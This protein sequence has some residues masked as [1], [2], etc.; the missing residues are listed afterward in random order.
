[1]GFRKVLQSVISFSTLSEIDVFKVT[2]NEKSLHILPVYLNCSQWETDF[3]SLYEAL[4]LCNHLDQFIVLGDL[5]A[6]TGSEQSILPFHSI[7]HS[8]DSIINTNGKKILSLCN[9]FQFEILNGAQRGDFS[10]N[11][12]FSNHLGQSV[13]D[14]VLAGLNATQY[15]AK[16]D[17]LN[18]LESDH[19]PLSVT[20]KLNDISSTH[21][22]RLAPKMRWLPSR[23][24][25]YQGNLNNILRYQN[26]VTLNSLNNIII[27]ASVKPTFSVIHKKSAW[28]D[29][30]C[31]KARKNCFRKLQI[32]RKFPSVFT[33]NE[34][35]SYRLVYKEICSDKTRLFRDNNVTR[36]KGIRSS[37]DFWKVARIINN[38]NA[39]RPIRANL[40]DLETHFRSTSPNAFG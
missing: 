16:L 2:D 3:N 36:L 25:Q 33:K 7:R 10:G 31:W 39:L 14:Y 9:D 6:R 22:S 30:E 38:N 12:T 37:K 35:N 34:Y 4:A 28:F 40:N 11:I 24:S 17:I 1:M 21:V 19:M 20:L 29:H 26:P 13:I 27:A 5:N 32:Y 18:Q 15:V 23:I 8:S